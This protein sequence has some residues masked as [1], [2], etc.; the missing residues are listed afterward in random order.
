M[1]D[2]DSAICLIRVTTFSATLLSWK[3]FYCC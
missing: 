1:S 2:A 3:L